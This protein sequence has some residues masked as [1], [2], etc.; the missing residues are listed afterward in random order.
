V[1]LYGH[2][3]DVGGLQK[4]A[5]E[6]RLFLIEDCAEA[7]GSLYKRTHV[8][9]FGTVSTF[10]FFGN[11]TI[12]TGE[13]GM[14]IL[15]D[16]VLYEKISL[17]KNQGNDPL[18]SYWHTVI[19]YNYRMTNLSA[20]IGLAQMEQANE[21]LK[22][23]RW[24]AKKYQDYLA[25]LPLR[26]HQEDIDYTHSYWMISILVNQAEDRDPLR[27]FLSSI[28]VET[29]PF[30]H[31]VHHL[32]MYEKIESG[33]SCKIAEQIS[34]RGINLPSFPDL[35]ELEVEFICEQIAK[36]Y[37]QKPSSYSVAEGMPEALQIST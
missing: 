8:G 14:I 7:F 34:S 20:A 2:P 3:C 10:S 35:T 33:Q 6:H 24:L 32:P 37:R 28:G 22:K 9:N 11:K 4:I 17:L 12:T 36:Y 25:P 27:H 13:G 21:I 18:R 16:P 29:R 1:H 23:K 26:I 19:G 30:F 5:N 31:P 15:Q